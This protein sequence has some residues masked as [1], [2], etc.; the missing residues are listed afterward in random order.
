MLYQVHPARMGFE[1]T[2]L[3]AI[4]TD[5]IHSCKSNYHTI[6]TTMVPHQ[7]QVNLETAKKNKKQTTRKHISIVILLLHTSLPS[8]IAASVNI[9]LSFSKL[10]FSWKKHRFCSDKVSLS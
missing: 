6:M 1:L 7:L 8:L 9:F 2:T 10:A 4:G 3:M 5:C